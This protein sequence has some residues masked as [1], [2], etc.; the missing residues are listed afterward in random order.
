[1][2]VRCHRRRA[3]L[4]SECVL[5]PIRRYAAHR[6]TSRGCACLVVHQV[7][8]DGQALHIG[9]GVERSPVGS[10]RPDRD[11]P[12][13]PVLYPGRRG[14]AGFT[15]RHLDAPRQRRA[16][17]GVIVHRHIHHG[18]ALRHVCP[19]EQRPSAR[20]DCSIADQFG[21]QS[22][23]VREIYLLGHQPVKH[24]VDLGGGMIR[25]DQKRRGLGRHNRRRRQRGKQG[26]EKKSFTHGSP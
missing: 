24:R 5:F 3:C 9:L 1:M 6:R 10:V 4:E 16:R 19:V 20:P 8:R 26:K 15:H 21:I 11:A 25:L 2:I 23:I 12:V 7:G 17:S 14:F 18:R 13:S 22:A